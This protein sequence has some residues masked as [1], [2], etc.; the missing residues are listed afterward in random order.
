MIFDTDIFIW[1]QRGNEKAA[2]LMEKTEERFLSIQSY[3][4]LLQCAKNKAQLKYTKV[5]LSDFGFAVLPLTE[6]I[7]HRAA[8]Y[9]EEFTLSSNLRAGDAI[10]AATASENNIT[11]ISSNSKHFKDIKDLKLKVFKP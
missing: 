8:I 3:M 9:I 7:G 10:I 5:F 2:K 6:N 4:E 1:V 11:L